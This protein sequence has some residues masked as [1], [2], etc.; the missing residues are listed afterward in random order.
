MHCDFYSTANR[1]LN[2]LI[3]MIV[4][5]T[6]END[7]YSKNIRQSQKKDDKNK[8]EKK[9]AENTTLIDELWKAFRKFVP[10][11]CIQDK[12]LFS[13]VAEA[14]GKENEKEKIKILLDQYV[15]SFSKSSEGLRKQYCDAYV[16]K[17][18]DKLYYLPDIDKA[19]FPQYSFILNIKFQLERPLITRDD[20]E[21]HICDNPVKKDKV[22]KIPVMPSSTWKGHLRWTAG[23]KVEPPASDEE[24]MLTRLQAVKLFGNENAAE[25]QYLDSLMSDETEQKRFIDELKQWTSKDR[26]RKG[27]LNFY[28]TFFEEIGL[29]VINPHSRKTKAGTNPISIES[30][31]T[32]STGTFSLLYV[33]FD[34]IGLP[35]ETA[36]NEV[37][38]DLDI[39]YDSLKKMMRTYGFSAKKSS[40][41]G[42]INEPFIEGIFEMKGIPL[43]RE[44]TDDVDA[45][46][47]NHPFAKLNQLKK[48]GET[49]MEK[50]NSFSKFKELKELIKRVKG[51]VQR[52]EHN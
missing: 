18:C 51:E 50:D 4:M 41:F 27:R 5:K 36:R 10:S 52:H 20:D 21:F 38:A 8:L 25:K 31:P 29:E 37:I 26:L 33:P 22:F 2:K 9:K 34:L 45:T 17:L 43:Y 39:I 11:P 42:L 46:D 19:Y 47:K 35:E 15:A 14:E 3:N 23:K 13:F 48:K 7:Q 16:K 24:R 49:V 12:I 40:G 28:P 30:V 44:M 1:E 6:D 32:G